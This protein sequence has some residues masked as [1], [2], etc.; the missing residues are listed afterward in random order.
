MPSGGPDRL[1]GRS[2]CAPRARL[3][4]PQGEDIPDPVGA[5]RE[6]YLRTAS[7]IEE[8]L[9]HLLDELVF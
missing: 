2:E 6:T 4:H 8:S 3:L 5:D 7:E 9:R 1:I